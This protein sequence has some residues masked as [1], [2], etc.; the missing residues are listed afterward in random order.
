MGA[1]R[2]LD[3]VV[4]DDL[5]AVA[6]RIA[7]VKKGA[8]ERNDAGRLESATGRLFIVD[9]QA[10]VAAIVRRLLAPL[11]EGNKLVTQIDEGHVVT[12]AAQLELEELTVKCQRLVD[13]AYLQRYMIEAH[14]ARSRGFYHRTLLCQSEG[15]VGRRTPERKPSHERSRVKARRR[16]CSIN[17]SAVRAS[18]ARSLRSV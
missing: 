16:S 13:V 4:A 12:L 6:P 10:E 7:E 14:D 11:L 8:V 3:V 2:E 18:S 15:Q 5:D 17:A 9:Y 1:L